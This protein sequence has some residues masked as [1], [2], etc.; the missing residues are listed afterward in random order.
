MAAPKPTSGQTGVIRSLTEY[1]IFLP[2]MWGGNISANEDRAVAFCTKPNMTGAP[3]TRAIP[4]GFV[5]S[6]HFVSNTQKGYV[7]VTGRIDRT[8][9]GLDPKDGG[10]QFD[11]IAP[12][13][14]ICAG[15]KRFVQITEPD[16][17]IFCI[18]CCKKDEDC[19]YNK[20]TKGCKA[21]LGG[22]YS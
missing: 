1:C 8:K 9:Y 19:P 11:T 5:K 7:Q 4:E 12:R 21:V 22:D 14:A 2:P 18:R 13:G 17:E 10:G 6:A 20:S 16:I 15:Y 3:N